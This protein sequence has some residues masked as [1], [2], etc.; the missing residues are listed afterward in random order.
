MLACYI[1]SNPSAFGFFTVDESNKYPPCLAAV[2]LTG[3]FS[4]VSDYREK[5]YLGGKT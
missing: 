3:S 2:P 4:A 1:Y 5:S